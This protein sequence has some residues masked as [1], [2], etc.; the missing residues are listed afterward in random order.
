MSA[1][2]E[3]NRVQDVYPEAERLE[4]I[5]RPK[6]DDCRRFRIDRAILDQRRLPKT[7]HP[8][9]RRE[10]FKSVAMKHPLL[11]TFS[12][13]CGMLIHAMAGIFLNFASV[14]AALA[15]KRQPFRGLPKRIELDPE[16]VQC[17]RLARWCRHHR[18]RPIRCREKARSRRERH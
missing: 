17:R 9:C 12:T 8:N 4:I 3:S 10:V 14:N 13:A 5:I 7:P 18:R 2:S 16:S 1:S 11:N 6:I 15:S